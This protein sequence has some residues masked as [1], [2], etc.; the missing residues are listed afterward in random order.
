MALLIYI[1]I[2][3]I[4]INGILQTF[5]VFYTLIK[6]FINHSL[7]RFSFSKIKMNNLFLIIFFIFLINIIFLIDFDT[8][9]ILDYFI[10]FKCYLLFSCYHYL[11]FFLNLIHLYLFVRLTFIINIYC[12]VKKHYNFLK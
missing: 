2:L 4:Y 12:I 11:P 10:L 3:F 1:F 8:F 5:T 9:L 7:Y 6:P